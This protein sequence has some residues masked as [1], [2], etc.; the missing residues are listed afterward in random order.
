MPTSNYFY[1]KD[2]SELNKST[3]INLVILIRKYYIYLK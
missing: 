2:K 1:T 3:K